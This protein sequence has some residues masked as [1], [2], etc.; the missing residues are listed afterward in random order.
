MEGTP[1]EYWLREFEDAGCWGADDPKLGPYCETALCDA[2][3]WDE[4]LGA[5]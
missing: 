4:V 2:E 3:F 5:Y 1:G